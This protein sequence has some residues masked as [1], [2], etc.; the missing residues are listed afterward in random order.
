MVGFRFEGYHKN[1][2][3]KGDK[4]GD[5]VSIAVLYEDYATL[6]KMRGGKLWDSF[7][8]MKQRVKNLP[9]RSIQMKYNEEF[10]DEIELYYDQIKRL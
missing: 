8:N 5:A 7:E 6:I 3:V 2:F 1:K 9:A 4:V 10:L